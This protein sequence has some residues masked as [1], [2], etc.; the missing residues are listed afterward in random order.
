MV[1]LSE[2][3]DRGAVEAAIA[4]YRARGRD[5][6]LAAY[7]FEGSRDYFLSY[8]GELFDSKPILGVAYGNQY[9]ERGP[10]R[11]EDFSGGIVATVRS[12]ERLG[13]STTTRAQ[14]RP[15]SLGASY[16]SRT[17]VYDAYGGDK[18]AGIIRFPGDPVVNV[19]SDAE[20]PY[21]DDPPSLAEPFGYRGE[22]LN[23]P[24]RVEVGGNA[25]LERA[26]VEPAA[27]RFWY[28]PKGEDFTFLAWAVV[29]GRAWVAG[30]GQDRVPRPEIEWQL[31]AV[32]SPAQER[33]SDRWWLQCRKRRTTWRTTRRSPRQPLRLATGS[34]SPESRRGGSCDG[35]RA[36]CGWT[37]RE[38]QL[39][40]ALSF[41]GPTVV[42]RVHA[43][44]VCLQS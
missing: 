30:V 35:Q 12:L 42:A 29:L 17:A 3:T 2:L 41:C 7:G 1:A 18:V 21:A 34:S 11:P 44:P 13:F 15:P 19:F 20:G 36:L 8:E 24:Q 16:A 40:A 25:L 9:P 6:F 39:H 28:R 14:F 38:A 27:V 43:A 37:T 10:L 26:R 33:W 32:P 31:Q 22:G 4:E 5:A 23:G